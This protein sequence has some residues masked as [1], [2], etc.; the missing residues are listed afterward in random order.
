MTWVKICLSHEQGW[1]GE[2]LK[3]V[4]TGLSLEDISLIISYM[5]WKVY[6]PQKSLT[7]HS[8]LVG[9]SE[10]EKGAITEVR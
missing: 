9:P 3:T 4:E 2:E 7:A 8:H 10:Y 6:M 1:R 5:R